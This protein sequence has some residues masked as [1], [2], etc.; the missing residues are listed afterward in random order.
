MSNQP[1]I[2]VVMPVYNGAEYLRE[3]L[4][5]ILA[6][7]FENFEFII[8]DDGSKD[9]SMEIAHEYKDARIRLFT[10]SNR[11]LAATLNR[12]IDLACGKYIARMDQD[13][14]SMPKRLEEQVSFMESHPKIGV[15]GTGAEIIDTHGTHLFNLS[16]PDSHFLILWSMCFLD[17]LLHPTIF[18]RR[19]L[20]LKADG[21]RNPLKRGIIGFPEDYD[22][23]ARMSRFT[24]FHNLNQNL[25]KLRRHKNNTSL[26]HANTLNSYSLKIS[27]KY[28]ENLLGSSLPEDSV[29]LFW[30]QETPSSSIGNSI[31]LISKIANFFLVA[32]PL[33][34]GE[35]NY[36]KRDTAWKLINITRRHLDDPLALSVILQAFRYDMAVP[37]TIINMAFTK[38]SR[39]PWAN[40]RVHWQ[41]WRRK[42]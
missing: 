10:Q 16:F 23:W 1:L 26:N 4:D 2:S 5:S 12:G 19:P 8:L 31:N 34:P 38:W 11:G 33:S 18:M 6:Q 14:I 42:I 22:L 39:G 21:Y 29:E 24:Q 32:Y 28:I 9:S 30:K 37:L 25:L 13:D 41:A 40:T 15:C 17:P 35:I 27:K 36:I 7:T 3:A 20:V